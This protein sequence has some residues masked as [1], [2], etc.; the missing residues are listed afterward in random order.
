MV[1]TV[2][3][4]CLALWTFAWFYTMQPKVI[5]EA[6]LPDGRDK[7]IELLEQQIRNLAP[8]HE[9]KNSLRR[10]TV[11]LAAEIDKF[12]NNQ[13]PPPGGPPNNPTTEEEKKRTEVWLQ[14]WRDARA[15]YDSH[16]FQ[17]KVAELIGAYQAKQIPV[18]N[19]EY[20]IKYNRMIGGVLHRGDGETPPQ[21][22]CLTDTC[23][24]RELAF[25][26]NARDGVITPD[27]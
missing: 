10:K 24:L 26:V 27:F 16:S 6:R 8:F 19:L 25:H 22:L 5:I 2:G 23:Q 1:V 14:Y 11:R 15:A 17:E 3:T 4:A 9:P 12:W 18:G 20:S 7:K 13:P 21:V